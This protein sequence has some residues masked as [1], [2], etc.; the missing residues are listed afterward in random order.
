MGQNKEFFAFHLFEV[1]VLLLRREDVLCTS[2]Y[3]KQITK[4]D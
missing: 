2:H 1:F 4:S 3:F